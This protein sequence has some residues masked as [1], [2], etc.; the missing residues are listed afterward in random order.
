MKLIRKIKRS[1]KALM[2]RKARRLSRACNGDITIGDTF[3]AAGVVFSG[4]LYIGLIWIG[5]TIYAVLCMGTA[6]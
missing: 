3:K 4:V 6:M 2:A 1:Y 5:I